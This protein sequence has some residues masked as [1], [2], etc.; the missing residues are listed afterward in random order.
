MS[1]LP[2]RNAWQSGEGIHDMT[3]SSYK[4]AISTTHHTVPAWG[5][6]H[7]FTATTK[8]SSLPIYLYPFL[9]GSFPGKSILLR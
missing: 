5:S 7:F 3:T 6:A 8:T 2:G 9:H 1:V 4:T